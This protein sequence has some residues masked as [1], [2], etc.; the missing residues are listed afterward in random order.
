MAAYV[1]ADNDI[2]DRF[3]ELYYAF[4]F[5]DSASTDQD[6][7]SRMSIYWDTFKAFIT[8]PLW[9]TKI[10]FDP[11]S[12]FR[13][14]LADIALLGAIP[15]CMLFYCMTKNIYH[16][17]DI[18]NSKFLFNVSLLFIIMMGLSNPIHSTASLQFVI[19][20]MA[21]LII[22]ELKKQTTI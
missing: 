14:I 9:G 18:N 5:Q 6:G 7:A 22:M 19:W 11:H 1:G 4:T 2:H 17:L 21:P 20:C 15:Y 3:M 16:F 12:T 10:D 8:S 13:D